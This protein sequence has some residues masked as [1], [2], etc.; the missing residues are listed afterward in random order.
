MFWASALQLHVPLWM[1]QLVWSTTSWAV[2][3]TPLENLMPGRSLSVQ[4][5][6]LA[7]PFTLSAVSESASWLYLWALLSRTGV[8]WSL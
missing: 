6:P 1:I 7:V 2:S 8:F 4:D 5:L 3:A